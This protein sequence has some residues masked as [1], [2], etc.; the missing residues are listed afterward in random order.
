MGVTRVTVRSTFATAWRIYRLLFRRSVATAAAVFVVV[1]AV[2]AAGRL[3]H[4]GLPRVALILV[5][6]ALNLAG[7]V[8][9]QGALI[10]IVRNIH[11]GRPP[12]RIATLYEG[13]WKRFWPLL[14]ASFLYAFGVIVGFVLLIVPGLI[15]AARWSLMAPLI[16]L[17]RRGVFEARR[18]SS[19]LVR[20]PPAFEVSGQ[21]PAVIA[22][23]VVAFLLLEAPLDAIGFAID[24]SPW[25]YLIAFAWNALTAPFAAHVYTTVYYRLADPERPVIAPQVESWRSV[26]VGA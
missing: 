6:A 23:V 15:A 19:E 5:S 8:V 21:T 10:A 26:W 16:V 1:E 25:Y 9:V 3:P 13:A 4:N 17:E 22:I 18:R 12:E 14:G 20:Q 11:E 7:P 24:S 2:D